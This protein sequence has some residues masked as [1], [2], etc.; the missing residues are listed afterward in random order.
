MNK[1]KILKGTLAG[2]L[3]LTIVGSAVYSSNALVYDSELE[4]KTVAEPESWG[5][6]PNEAQLQYHDDELAAFIHFG[7]NTFTGNEW[8]DGTE[9]PSVFN[10]TGDF[11]ESAKSMV[12][13]LKNAGFSKIQ[14]EQNEKGWL[15][16]ICKRDN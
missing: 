16:A 2:T 8:G 1:S 14:V 10:P 4:E 6:L 3:A 9:S 12:E 13:A 7:V 11:G 15:C 5:A